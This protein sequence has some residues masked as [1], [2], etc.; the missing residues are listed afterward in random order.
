VFNVFLLLIGIC[1]AGI[2][3]RGDGV[4]DLDGRKIN[5]LSDTE[6]TVLFFVA[7]ACPISNRYAPEFQR[8]A[9]SWARTG[10]QA[11]LVYA[12]DESNDEV[13]AHLLAYGLKIPA[14][15]DPRHNLAHRSGVTVTPEAAVFDK[16]GR[17][18]YHGRIDD[19][20]VNFGLSKPEP[21]RRDLVDAVNA[22]LAGKPVP[23]PGGPAVGC[24][25]GP[26]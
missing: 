7:T 2:S 14:L 20:W 10:V 1:A 9:E 3:C 12:G 15:R 24:S 8:L 6:A 16:D 17:V 21:S 23:G 25:L 5:A 19:R 4:V 18:L 26:T 11:R 13:R 22:M